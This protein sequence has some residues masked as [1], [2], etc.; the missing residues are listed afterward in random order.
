MLDD[1]EVELGIFEKVLVLN[2]M[3]HI[4]D[5]VFL[6]FDDDEV[7]VEDVGLEV[8]ELIEVDTDEGQAV[9]TMLQIIEDDD[10]EITMLVIYD[11]DANE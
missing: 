6:D 1:D 9:T 3:A 4:D 10:D 2:V 5:M 11:A 7:E 8:A